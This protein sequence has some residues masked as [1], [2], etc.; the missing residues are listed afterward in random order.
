MSSNQAARLAVTS[1]AIIPMKS[2]AAISKPAGEANPSEGTHSQ[3]G[4]AAVKLTTISLGLFCSG[5]MLSD[6]VHQCQ[7]ETVSWRRIDRPAQHAAIA[8]LLAYIQTPAALSSS[9]VGS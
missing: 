1:V 2:L 5:R 3:A 8:A 9:G 4:S 6:I 7:E